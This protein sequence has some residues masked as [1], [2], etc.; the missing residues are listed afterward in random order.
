MKGKDLIFLAGGALLA[1]MLIPKKEAEAAPGVSIIGIPTAGEAPLDIGGIFGGIASLFG[2]MPTPI[3]PEINIPEFKW[4]DINIPEINIPDIPEFVMPAL[5]DELKIPDIPSLIPDIPGTGIIDRLLKGESLVETGG[6]VK[7]IGGTIVDI[8]EAP[9]EVGKEVFDEQGLF[10][11]DWW[12]AQ[13]PE[14]ALTEKGKFMRAYGAE[15]EAIFTE[16]GVEYATPENIDRLIAAREKI[17]GIEAETVPPIGTAAYDVFMGL[18]PKPYQPI[19][20]KSIISKIVPFIDVTPTAEEIRISK[21]TPDPQEALLK[22]LP[23]YSIRK[24]LGKI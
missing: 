14:F 5:P 17:T 2:A 23:Y 8:V 24:M 13:M 18:A 4:P 15:S 12:T 21:L 3:V 10:S 9:F 11:E 19:Q 16:A 22:T 6:I 1:Y 20:P 7:S